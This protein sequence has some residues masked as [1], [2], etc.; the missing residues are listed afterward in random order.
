MGN[1]L[2]GLSSDKKKFGKAKVYECEDAYLNNGSEKS[3]YYFV[4][5][6]CGR[7]YMKCIKKIN[8]NTILG[9]NA[10][11]YEFR[12]NQLD[13]GKREMTMTE[14]KASTPQETYE[15]GAVTFYYCE[16][17]DNGEEWIILTKNNLEREMDKFIKEYKK[18]KA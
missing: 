18:I 8:E 12:K 17:Y 2:V 14:I 7:F 9:K 11:V 1:M 6:E 4:S 15:I 13:N 5:Y 16:D 3:K 10:S